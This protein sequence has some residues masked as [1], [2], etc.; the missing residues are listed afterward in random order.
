MLWKAVG[1]PCA[2]E[3]TL[4]SMHLCPA[5][6]AVSSRVEGGE[7]IEVCGFPGPAPSRMNWEKAFGGDRMVGHSL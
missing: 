1:A 2:N 3:G 6:C 7:K 4:L 5:G